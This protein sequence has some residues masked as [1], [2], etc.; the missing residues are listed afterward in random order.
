MLLDIAGVLRSALADPAIDGAVVVQGTDTIEETSFFWD[1]LLDGAKP[2]VVTGAMRASDE[3]SFD[4]PA[5]LLDAVRAAAAPR[6]RGQGVVVALSGTLEPA[7]DVM[8]THTT[9]LDTFRSPNGGSLGRVGPD[10][11]V[12]YRRRAG[13]RRVATDTAA[14]RVHLRDRDR[15]HGWVDGGRRGRGRCGWTGGG[16]DG[17]GKHLGARA[18][19][20]GSRDRCRDPGRARVALPLGFGGSGLCVRRRRSELGACRGDHRGPPVRAEGP[21]RPRP[22]RGRRPGP[23]RSGRAACRSGGPDRCPSTCSSRDG[24]PHSPA[25]VASAGS[26]PSGSATVA[27]RSRGPR[28][29]SRRGPT[30]TQSASRSSP[31]RW[32]SPA[33]PMRTSISTQAA[34]A[35]RH[36]DLSGAATLAAGLAAVRAAASGGARPRRLAR[37][38]R[39]GLRSM[40]PL[41]DRRRPRGRRTRTPVRP[42]GARPPRGA[43]EQVCPGRGGRGR[44]TPDPP[45]GSSGVTRTAIRRASC[46]RPPPDWSVPGC[47]WSARRTSSAPSQHLARTSCSSGWS[48]R[49]IRAGS[50]PTRTSPGPS[51]P[52]ATWPRTDGCPST[53]W[54]RFG[55]MVSTPPS[56]GGSAAAARSARIR[57]AGRGSGWQKCFADGSL[58]SG[59]RHCSRTSSRSPTGRCRPT[60]AEA[61]GSRR[62]MSWPISPSGPPPRG[63]ASQIHAI[64]DAAVRAA[65]DVLEPTASRVPFMPRLEHVQLLD[66]ADRGRFADGGIAAS[67]QPSHLGSDAAQARRLWGER[68]ERSGYTWASIARTGRGHAVR[69]RRPGRAVRSVAGDRPRR[70]SGG[71]A[72]G[73]RHPAVRSRP[74]AL[75]RARAALRLRGPAALGERD[76]PRPPDRRPA[77]G[78]AWSSRRQPSTSPP[79]PAGRLRRPGPSIVVVDGRV[80]FEV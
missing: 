34:L 25:T 20:R 74:V 76:G 75:D 66:P 49:T 60:V 73:A 40:G 46:M 30:P 58:G 10:G 8:K 14:E 5:N 29:R 71:P 43:R 80:V 52:T 77:S 61:S 26:R 42:V 24:S 4:G 79:S 39:L 68:A 63:I 51:P 28:S 35:A 2:V 70:A 13:R 22:G 62:P 11:V 19:G 45:G 32:R 44:S 67:V 37:G 54:P 21:G 41:A 56:N 3:A 23:G 31:T 6:L 57:T 33:S 15:G 69:D 36:I 12:L 53:S 47:P 55:R 9:A 16:R 17:I 65:L 48:R 59:R 78:R 18:P 72:M 27:S 64:G 38:A 7:D 1:L 50:L